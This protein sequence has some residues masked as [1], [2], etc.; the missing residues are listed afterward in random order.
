[1][2][3]SGRAPGASRQRHGLARAGPVLAFAVVVACLLLAGP[4]VLAAAA[5]DD[6][7]EPVELILFWGDGCPHCETERAFLQELRSDYPDLV[8][9]E[10]EV[11]GNAENRQLFVETAAAAGVAARAVPTTFI[12]DRVWVGFSSATGDEI[13]AVVDAAFGDREVEPSES[14]L[15]DV[16]LVGGVDLGGRSMLVSTVII[17][18]V[19]GV[20]PCSLWVL[21][22][23]LALVLHSGSRQRVV[24]VGGLF[25]IVTSAMYGLY[26]VGAYSALSYARLLPWI[27][28][29]VALVAIVLGVLQLKDGF[30]VT[31][32]PSLSVDERARP[33]MYRRMRELAVV[34]RPLAALLG[35]TVALAVGVSLLETPCTLGLPILWTNL[36][37]ENDVP[38]GGAAVL[39]AVYLSVFLLDE[40]VVFVA[41]VATMRALKVQEHHGRALKVVSGV[42]MI[43]LA[44]TMLV[45][46]EAME[47][48]GGTLAVFGIAVMLAIVGI[49]AQQALSGHSSGIHQR[50][51]DIG[52]GHTRGR[53]R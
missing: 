29:S 25:L 28:R 53:H 4:R 36:L 13:R 8:I 2:N 6:P 46:P 5:G 21:S 38:L 37:A 22:M 15:V 23:L 14:R 39:F 42:L 31:S 44:A 12:G 33:G 35:A 51:H 24:M 27:Q 11:W 10:F 16:P 32:G 20:N 34:D 17:G 26:I 1:M 41:V 18:F 9:R 19:D 3:W 50:P 48:M 52:A 49:V 40:L 43:T 7:S 45:R 30:G 47:T